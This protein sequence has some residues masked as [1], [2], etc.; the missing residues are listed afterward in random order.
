MTKPKVEKDPARQQYMSTS[1][2]V[3]LSVYLLVIV[4]LSLAL[5][6]SV[7]PNIPENENWAGKMSIELRY[8]ILVAAGG[9]LGSSLDVL[10]RFT[11]N[12]GNR[13]LLK[14]WLLWY[15]LRVLFGTPLAMIGY[16]IIRGTIVAPGADIKFLNPFGL[17][18]ISALIGM[19]ATQSIEKLNV[20]AQA[21][22]NV[23]TELEK[24]IDRIGTALGVSSLDNYQ[25]FVCL[26]VEGEN[27][28]ITYSSEGETLLLFAGRT[29]ELAIWFQ[30]QKPEHVLAEEIQITD[31]TDAK[32]VEFFLQ[33]DS[34]NI[35]VRKRQKSI[36]FDVT[37]KSPNVK[38][39][40]EADKT[41]DEGELWIVVSQKLRFI[42]L[43]S[44]ILKIQQKVG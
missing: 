27:G 6:F 11:D 16:F 1:S 39:Q 19:F 17:S 30:P 34:N 35:S 4:G 32:T 14:K 12:V 10:Y 40:F 36:S 24:R 15:F 18:C 5:I 25:G 26:S 20:V 23:E 44:V 21:L 9:F 41:H 43:V 31:G 8:L 33:P 42:T 7:W 13:R 29:Y 37:K 22:F 2:L 38:F 28:E 3:F